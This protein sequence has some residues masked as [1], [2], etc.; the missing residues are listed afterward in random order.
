MKLYGI[1]ILAVIAL[2][3]GLLACAAITSIHLAEKTVL[4]G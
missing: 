1:V 2:V 4:G 3:G